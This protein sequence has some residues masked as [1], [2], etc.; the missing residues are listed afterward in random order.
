M[1]ELF[2]QPE[3]TSSQITLRNLRQSPD[4]VMAPQTSG[5]EGHNYPRMLHPTLREVFQASVNNT[6]FGAIKNHPAWRYGD[7]IDPDY[8]G[9]HSRVKD[10]HYEAYANSGDHVHSYE[11]EMILKRWLDGRAHERE[12]LASAAGKHFLAGS[13]LMIADPATWVG[14][15]MINRMNRLRQKLFI[16]PEFRD[17]L[18][19]NSATGKATGT[20]LEAGLITFVILKVMFF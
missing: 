15:G 12:Q 4:R 16:R 17:A 18:K 9:W 6:W 13:A 7:K 5:F 1:T 2:S 14:I 10:T 3:L 11:D 19:L 20:Q 8:P